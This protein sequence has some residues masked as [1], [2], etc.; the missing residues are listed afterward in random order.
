MKIKKLLNVSVLLFILLIANTNVVH[1]A[2]NTGSNYWNYSEPSDTNDYAYWNGRSVVKSPSTTTNE[3]KW[4]QSSMNYLID[5]GYIKGSKLAVDGSF[6]PASAN[7]CG[8]LQSKLNIKSDKSFG[9]TTIKSVKSL[10]K[11]APWKQTK[12]EP[13]KTTTELN[14]IFPVKGLNEKNITGK[15]GYDDGE[16]H[17][18]PLTG[19]KE[20]VHSGI[21]IS[22]KN[23][24]GKDILAV[25][26]GIVLFTGY[27]AARGN[28]IVIFHERQNISSLYEHLETINVKE[29]TRVSAGTKI[30]TL[31]NSGD[32][33]YSYPYHLH[34]GLMNGKATSVD[35]DV[36]KIGGKTNT[37]S[38]DPRYNKK[39]KYT[40]KG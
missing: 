14:L 31:G 18:R 21:D 23:C 13:K 29:S 20:R 38:P 24:R 28:Y 17:L 1:A 16:A 39:I 15:Y 6:G 30:G 40:Y 35:Y 25:S 9:P 36:W 3:I 22:A 32:K 5:V 7:L 37:F 4:M 26:D 12:S 11:D 10:L 27:T 8:V 19:K 2:S 33:K 34:F